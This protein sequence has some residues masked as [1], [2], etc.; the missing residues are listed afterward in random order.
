MAEFNEIEE[1]HGFGAPPPHL[2]ERIHE[3]YRYWDG[4]RGERD[5]PDRRDLDPLSEIPRLLS[6]VWLLDVEYDPLRLRYRLIGSDLTVAGAPARV[7]VY[8]ETQP[9]S[10]EGFDTIAAFMSCCTNRKVFW[11]RGQ[12]QLAHLQHIN[13]V[14][15]LALPLTVD[16]SDSVMMLMMMTIYDW[17]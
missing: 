10:S 6:A 8:V 7:G 4:K 16:R 11:R 14:Q 13:R 2:D 3:L 15:N 5:M 12:P 17:R 9:Q 1:Q